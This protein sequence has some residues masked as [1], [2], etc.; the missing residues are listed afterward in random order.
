MKIKAWFLATVLCALVFA[1]NSSSKEASKEEL[2]PVTETQKEDPL[3]RGKYLVDTNGCHDCH[4]PKQ[5]TEKG[6]EL[7][8]DRILSGH[9]ADQALAPY[10]EATAKSYVLFSPDLTAAIGP[11]G[12]SFSANL[13]PHETGIGSWTEKQ[14]FTAIRKGLYKGLEGSRPLLPP[15]PWEHYANFTDEDLSSIFAYLKSLNPVDNVVPAAII[16][17][18]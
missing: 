1:C 3:K 6:L 10:D 13:T 4:S 11:W 8:P 7:I 2:V 5:I 16:N 18:Q 15:M 14:F 12:T 17:G 9:P